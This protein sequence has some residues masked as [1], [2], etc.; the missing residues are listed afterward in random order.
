M[1]PFLGLLYFPGSKCDKSEFVGEID[2]E[3]RV[4][5]ALASWRFRISSATSEG[6][7]EK[8]RNAWTVHAALGNPQHVPASEKRSRREFPSTVPLQ[9]R[10][11]LEMLALFPNS[12]Q[13]WEDN[14]SKRPQPGPSNMELLDTP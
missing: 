4:S 6:P 3:M 13:I 9:L 14:V 5:P 7:R 10:S 1:N 8:R 11:R 12:L 2:I